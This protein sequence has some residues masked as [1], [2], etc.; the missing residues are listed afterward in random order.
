MGDTTVVAFGALTVVGLALI[1]W[2]VLRR[3][4]IPTLSGAALLF[5]LGGAWVAGLPGAVVGVIPLAFL[6]RRRPVSP[7]GRD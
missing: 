6:R 3:A 4:R 1:A 5:V 7:A 2:G